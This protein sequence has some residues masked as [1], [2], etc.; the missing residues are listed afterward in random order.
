MTSEA[1]AAGGGRKAPPRSARRR[2]RELAV[3]GLY[4]WLLSRADAGAVEAHL[5]D[6]PAFEKCDRDHFRALL[7]G[8]IGSLDELHAAIEPHLDRRVDELSPVEHAILL[9]G[10]YELARHPEIPYRVVINEAV[11]LAKTF[12]G[13]DGYKY[14]NGVLDRVAGR[15]RPVEAQPR[16]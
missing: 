5:S 9:V 10:A 4:E 12:G 16:G 11:E 2:S 7:H 1:G 14:V 15:L 13:T 6:S 3:Q 8:V